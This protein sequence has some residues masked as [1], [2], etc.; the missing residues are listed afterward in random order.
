MRQADP[1]AH[2]TPA[3]HQEAMARRLDAARQA[4]ASL[5]KRPGVMVLS[6]P[7]NRRYLTGFT[8]S[9][10]AAIFTSAKAIFVTDFRYLDQAASECPGWEIV[11]QGPLMVDTVAE[12]LGQLGEERVGF[13][14]ELATFAWYEDLATRLKGFEFVPVGPIVERIREVKEDAEIALIR[15]AAAITDQALGDVVSLL[16]PGM[17]EREI[18]LEIEYRM[19]KIG[20][21][22]AAFPTIV[23]SGARSA[24]PHG[25]AS[26]KLLASGDFVTI[27]TGA[28][29][30][31]YCSDLT[32]TFALSPI[33]EEQEKVYALVSEAQ[34]KSLAAVKPGITGKEV[35]AV[36]R[37]II[38]AAGHGDH[39]GHGLGHSLG[40]AVHETPRLSPTS[41]RV[42]EAGNVVTVEPG[43]YVTGWGGVR[44]ED[45][46]VVRP[47]GC[48]VLSKFPKKLMVL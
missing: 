26:E 45:L 4:L 18:A 10:G 37:D 40:L 14:R 13:E 24:L 19:R 23:A 36:S 41:D 3:R 47:E 43:V 28:K 17:P 25:R 22:D 9:S 27:D 8:G 15:Q 44:I 16:R 30:G 6:S 38:G 29:F 32:R 11:R 20:A 31:G 34:E 2:L 39:Y 21:D 5:E 35:D 7:E 33:S 1:T 46:V 12:V 48:E 42:L